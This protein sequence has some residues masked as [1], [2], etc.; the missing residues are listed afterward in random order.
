MQDATQG[1]GLLVER[2]KVPTPNAAKYVQQLC[3]HFAHKVP[4]RVE[5]DHGFADLPGGK[6]S[7]VSSNDAL[8]IEIAAETDEGMG[9]AKY[10]LEDHLLRFAF[11]EKL[12]VLT[13][14]RTSA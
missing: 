11:R 10:I 13:W 9:K 1:R 8:S 6:L 2:A 14:E 3:K 7:M 4:A 5:G 12:A